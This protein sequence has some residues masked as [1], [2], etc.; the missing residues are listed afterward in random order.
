MARRIVAKR[1]VALPRPEWRS[2]KK[3]SLSVRPS[4]N[5]YANGLVQT[6]AEAGRGGAIYAAGTE[7]AYL[8]RLPVFISKKIVCNGTPQVQR[9]W[10]RNLHW[11]RHLQV[12]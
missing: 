5:F 4:S 7:Y 6:H 1:T 8:S 12:Q 3:K 10:K 2:R 9:Q 11:E